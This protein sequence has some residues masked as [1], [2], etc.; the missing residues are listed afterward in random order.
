[1]LLISV[2]FVVLFKLS[3][4]KKNTHSFAQGISL[5][6]IDGLILAQTNVQFP[7]KMLEPMPRIVSNTN[8]TACPGQVEHNRAFIGIDK[9]IRKATQQMIKNTLTDGHVTARPR[10]SK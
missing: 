3:Y 1:M 9:Q 5:T 7:L 4:A 10:Y 8:T 2:I 6:E